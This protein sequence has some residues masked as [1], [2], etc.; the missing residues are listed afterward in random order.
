V[1]EKPTSE[2]DR[3]IK[4]WRWC[5]DCG[6]TATDCYQNSDDTGRK[7][8]PDCR[9]RDAAPVA[10]HLPRRDDAV[11]TWLKA[12]RDRS[13]GPVM[14]RWRAIDYLLELY[15]DHADTG[16]PLGQHACEPGD[17][18]GENR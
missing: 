12:N 14:P 11:A 10:E 17:G 15:R 8:C 13:S 3:A 6:T 5:W 9:H 4:H 16:T 1:S 18:S 7:C 2:F